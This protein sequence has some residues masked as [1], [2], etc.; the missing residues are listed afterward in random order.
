MNKKAKVII[1]N[2]YGSNAPYLLVE[3]L[4]IH[5]KMFSYEFRKLLEEFKLTIYTFLEEY[6]EFENTIWEKITD[7]DNWYIHAPKYLAVSI[8]SHRV[9]N[10]DVEKTDEFCN[11]ANKLL[12]EEIFIQ[13]DKQSCFMTYD[14]SCYLFL[15]KKFR[16]NIEY[17]NNLSIDNLTMHFDYNKTLLNICKRKYE[18]F[19]ANDDFGNTVLELNCVPIIDQSQLLSLISGHALFNSPN[20]VIKISQPKRDLSFIDY[21]LE[22]HDFELVKEYLK[23]KQYIISTLEAN[24]MR[25]SDFR[26]SVY[27]FIKFVVSNSAELGLKIINCNPIWSEKIRLQNDGSLTRYGHSLLKYLYQSAISNLDIITLK[28]IMENF[29][30]EYNYIFNNHRFDIYSNVENMF[31]A[32]MTS[33]RASQ[34]IEILTYIN[35]VI[36]RK[37]NNQIKENNHGNDCKPKG[38]WGYNT[39]TGAPIYE[40]QLQDID[41]QKLR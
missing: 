30:N 7:K 40:W 21:S 23:E 26:R 20:I 18:A 4:H 37:Y 33:K 8:C 31:N 17:T 15:Y 28:S 1:I 24:P 39:V 2:F 25:C 41:S 29:D 13:G 14:D 5:W 3:P 38:V 22:T 10:I 16:P 9:Y 32:G 27:I 34:A 35:K 6:K 11:R 12:G 36:L 19:N